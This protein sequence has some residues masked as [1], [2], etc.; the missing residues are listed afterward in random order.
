M[1]MVIVVEVVV[2]PDRGIEGCSSDG[3]SESGK[4]G[5]I[6]SVLVATYP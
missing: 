3:E 1:V 2:N 4:R 6:G 5:G